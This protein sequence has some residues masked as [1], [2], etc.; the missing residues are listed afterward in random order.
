MEQINEDFANTDVAI[1]VGANDVTNP[2]ARDD[3]GSPIFGM[4]ILN[5][6]QAKNV[7][8]LEARPGRGLCRDRE[9]ALP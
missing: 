1:V 6:D 5:V 8:V 9:H 4:P 7:Y 2:A 3:P